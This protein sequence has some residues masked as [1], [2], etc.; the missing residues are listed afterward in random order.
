MAVAIVE[1]GGEIERI[2]RSQGDARGGRSA[3]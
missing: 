1:R 3:M 2:P